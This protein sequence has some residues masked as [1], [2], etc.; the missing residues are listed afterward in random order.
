MQKI[1]PTAAGHLTPSRG[2]GAFSRL[3]VAE[4]YALMMSLAKQG[5]ILRIIRATR[6]F[7]PLVVKFQPTLFVATAA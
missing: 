7:G 1:G 5:Q 6:C 4:V 2:A 3:L